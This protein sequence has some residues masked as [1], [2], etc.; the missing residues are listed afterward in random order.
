M[1]YVNTCF[2]AGGPTEQPPPNDLVSIWTYVYAA[3]GIVTLV[4]VVIIISVIS[5]QGCKCELI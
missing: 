1:A 2:V 5:M 3:A 4:V